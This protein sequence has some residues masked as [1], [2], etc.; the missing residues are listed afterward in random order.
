[1]Q[2]K[3]TRQTVR[4]PAVVCQQLGVDAGTEMQLVVD[5]NQVVIRPPQAERLRSRG[6]FLVWPLIV[7]AVVTLGVYLYWLSQGYPVLWLT[8][9]DYSIASFVIGCGLVSGTLLFAGFFIKNR[10][11][12]ADRLAPRLYWRNLPAVL[13]AFVVILG[14]SLVGLFWVFGQMFPGASF[15]RITAALV[16]MVFLTIANAFMVGAALTIDARALT[17]LLTVVIIAGV[18]ISMAAN[19]QRQWWQYNLSFLGTTMASNAW[20][21]NLTLLMSALL[22]IALI[23]YL[24]VLLHAKYPHN[25]RLTALR[26]ILTLIAID[27]GLV[28][29]FPNDAAWH[30]L[31]DEVAGMLVTMITILIVGLRWL[32][33]G[34][35][36][37]FLWGS[38]AAGAILMALNLGFR[39]FRWPSLT[40]FEIQGFAIGFGWLLLLFNRIRTLAAAGTVAWPVTIELDKLD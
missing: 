32:L 31:H 25:W 9:G 16:F 38:Y 26:V 40:A 24:F 23:D 27:L 33:P 37:E 5:N 15:D 1:M 34:V 19:G 2:D 10:K 3:V 28:G 20:Q 17:M 6:L 18:V 35:T 14:E 13:L 11:D 39:I 21:F 29:V 12:S 30:L 7:S 36:R 22:M 8:G 4:L